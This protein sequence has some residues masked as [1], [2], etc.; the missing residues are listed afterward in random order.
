MLFHAICTDFFAFLAPK[1]LYKTLNNFSHNTTQFLEKYCAVVA[2][3]VQCFLE[4]VEEFVLNWLL[5]NYIK[6]IVYK[7]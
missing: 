5:I 3:I 2:E 7:K 4:D 6:K 1:I